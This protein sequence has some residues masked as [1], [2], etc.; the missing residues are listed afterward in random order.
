MMFRR[1]KTKRKKLRKKLLLHE[2]S[3]EVD[4]PSVGFFFFFCKGNR[5]NGLAVWLS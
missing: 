4:T 2:E 5:R 3:G 1:A